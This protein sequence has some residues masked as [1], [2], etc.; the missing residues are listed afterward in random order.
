LFSDLVEALELRNL[1]T[2]ADQTIV[3]AEARKESRGAHARD[4][5]PERNDEEWMKHTL[6]WQKDINT[7]RTKLTYRAVNPNTLDENEM[8]AIPPFKR[9]CALLF[10]PFFLFSSKLTSLSSLCRLSAFSVVLSLSVG[11]GERVARF[12]GC[13]RCRFLPLLSSFLLVCSSSA[14][15]PLFF[16][17]LL[18]HSTLASKKLSSIILCLCARR[19]LRL[20]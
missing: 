4:D 10:F 11:G 13:R 7:D 15:F 12:A 2:C 6:S 8:K 1:L 19:E 16:V 9:T 5:I 14:V 18:I 3:S 20:G 17:L